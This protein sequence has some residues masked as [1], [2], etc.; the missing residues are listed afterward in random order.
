VRR[1]WIRR[2]QI[3]LLLIDF[4]AAAL[5]TALAY[6]VRFGSVSLVFAPQMYLALSVVLPIG[7]I[8]TV[9]MNR[10][11]ADRF[12][13]AGGEEFQ[14]VMTAFV[15]LIG[16]IAVAAYAF[17]I[18]VARGYVLV[19]L[20]LTLVLTLAGRYGARMQLHRRRR[21]GSAM[22]SV[23][24]VGSP[25]SVRRLLAHI[26]R[27]ASAGMRIVGACVPAEAIR[28]DGVTAELR[29]L[30]APV[31]GD[32]DSVADLTREMGV[33]RVA[34]T[35]SAELGPQRMRWIA[36]QL[37]RTA[38]DLLVAPG[39]VDTTGSRLHVMPVAGVPLL[40]VERPA[41]TGVRRVFK[42]AMDRVLAVLILLL[43]SPVY[44]AVALAVG[45]TTQGPVFFVQKRVGRN[46]HTFR[47]VKFR[48]M[49]V[50]AEGRR[51]DLET[52]NWHGADGVLFK[53]HD[54]PRVTR[55]GRLIRRASL[56]ELPQLFNVLT[57]SMSLVGPRPPLPSEVAQYGADAR[58]RL[59]VKPGITGLWQVSGRSD[60][61][62]DESVRLD[63]VY[64]ENWSPALD[65]SILLKTVVAV[66][67]RA[68]AY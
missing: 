32:I 52:S 22:T 7:W 40:H 64:V 30:G 58:R 51:G 46:G 25:A 37:E 5:G 45:L 18:D 26:R 14:R 61:S 31:L 43:L 21:H 8:M 39:L 20:P 60:L 56:D 3:E 53:M 41:F 55:V 38:T 49:Y 12:L 15:Y 16:S 54:D 67:R 33:D 48:S 24:L 57:G 4:C 9:A 6:G 23:I 28:D 47:M 65:I 36:W 2:Y 19:A 42:N 63:L 29:R 13:G 1:T 27:D 35:S 59:L 68:G 17:Q 34:V 62:W 50:D 10:A 66:L 44:V 11:Y